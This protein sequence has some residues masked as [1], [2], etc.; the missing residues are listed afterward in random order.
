MVNTNSRSCSPQKNNDVDHVTPTTTPI[1]VPR[2]LCFTPPDLE[3]AQEIVDKVIATAVERVGEIEKEFG[4]DDTDAEG[5]EDEDEVTYGVEEINNNAEDYNHS[6]YSSDNFDNQGADGGRSLFSKLFSFSVLLYLLVSGGSGAIL[7]GLRL[8]PGLV[9]DVL[10][11]QVVNIPGE[12]VTDWAQFLDLSKKSGDIDALPL[13]LVGAIT[14]KFLGW[15]FIFRKSLFR[16]RSNFDTGF[17]N[18]SLLVMFQPGLFLVKKLHNFLQICGF[19]E[20][21]L[22]LFPD[23]KIHI[24][25]R[26]VD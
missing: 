24:N 13:L 16:R 17:L 4:D 20:S 26:R 9:D 3:M 23:I 6:H 2:K 11:K 12:L 1:P 8:S 7:L 18:N 14:L 15:Y 22:N 5:R 19:N 25:P 21:V 10:S